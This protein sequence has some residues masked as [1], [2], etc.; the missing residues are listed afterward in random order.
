[1]A[2]ASQDINYF[3]ERQRSKLNKT[4]GRPANNRSR[5]MPPRSRPLPPPP[6][7][8]LEPVESRLDFQVARMLDEPSPRLISQQ[9]GYIPPSSRSPYP[10]ASYPEQQQPY[11]EDSPRTRRFSNGTAPDNQ[12]TFYDKFGTYDERRSQLKDDLKREYNEYLQSQQGAPRRKATAGPVSSGARS[13]RR[14]Q[15]QGDPT[16]I[17]PWEKDGS[18]S[19]RSNQNYNDVSSSNGISTAEYI[20]NSS[21]SRLLQEHDEQ[22]IRDREEYIIE[23]ENQ[24]YELETRKRQIEISMST[25]FVG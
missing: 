12:S 25:K 20:T 11:Y 14:V 24:I 19:S 5:P 15:F 9:G 8:P 17:A 13:S 22:Y 6:P 16:V 1:M 21:R 23:L 2:T 7:R 3:I 18:K 4:N 10:P